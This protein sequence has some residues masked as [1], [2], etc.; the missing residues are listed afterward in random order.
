MSE[1][2]SING[3]AAEKWRMHRQ[4]VVPGREPAIKGQWG[5][6]HCAGQN[7]AGRLDMVQLPCKKEKLH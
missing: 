1:L 4:A 6:G 2:T 7:G 5:Y 3:N